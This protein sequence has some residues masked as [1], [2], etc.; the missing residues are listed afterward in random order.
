MSTVALVC[1]CCGKNVSTRHLSSHHLWEHNG[2]KNRCKQT[3]LPNLFTF[4]MCDDVTSEIL[5]P[6]QSLTATPHW[7]CQPRLEPLGVIVQ[8]W[9]QS[10]T[11]ESQCVGRWPWTSH[12]VDTAQMAVWANQGAILKTHLR[13]KAMWTAY[14]QQNLAPQRLHN[15]IS[16]LLY[17]KYIHWQNNIN[18]K[19]LRWRFHLSI[20]K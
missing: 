6:W 20:T 16:P 4:F 2:Q 8:T 15:Y 14:K 3:D 18:C 9:W 19:R 1:S 7:S 10:V 11:L 5:L 12:V 17:T 13:S